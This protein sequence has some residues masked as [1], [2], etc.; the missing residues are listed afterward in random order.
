MKKLIFPISFLSVVI[1]MAIWSQLS[2]AKQPTDNGQRTIN[3]RLFASYNISSVNFFHVSGQYGIYGDGVK[4]F[5][6][7]KISFI[8]VSLSGDSVLLQKP[9]FS[10]K[11]HAVQFVPKNISS[12]FKIKSL[13]PDYK[14]R[15]YDDELQVSAFEKSLRKIGRASCRER[16]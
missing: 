2:V 16:V 5:D 13:Q 4:L 7:D 9:N 15:T 8:T 1:P 14:V 10:A 12:S 6:A 3:I 11:F